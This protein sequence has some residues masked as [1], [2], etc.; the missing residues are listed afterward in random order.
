MSADFSQIME[1]LN[2]FKEESDVSKRLKE[3]TGEI[4]DLLSDRSEIA[5]EK[6]LFELEGLSSLEM[7]SYHRTQLWDI[8][9]MLESLKN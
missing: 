5:V 2:N 1:V 8:A 9:S 3:K 6:A 4:I 7:S